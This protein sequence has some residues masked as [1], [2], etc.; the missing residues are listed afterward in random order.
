MIRIGPERILYCDTDSIM[1]LLPKG[2][3]DMT[4]HGL[5]NWV[6][7]YPENRIQRLTALAPKF[8]FLQFDGDEELLKSKG[9]MMSHENR[10]LLNGFTLGKQM[11]E[12]FYPRTNELQVQ[13][14]FQGFIGMK[15]MLIG[16]NSTSPNFAYGTM[17]TKE[18]EDKKLQPVISKRYLVPF[19]QERNVIYD[20]VTA[21][22]YI[23]RIYTLPKGY[24]RSVEQMSIEFY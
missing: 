7:E 21:L 15:N 20:E 23:P 16:I 19:L 10:R 11:L 17:L 4:G 12:L 8:Y 14:P 18:T 22:N 5:G 6:N 1:A 3:P 9:I 2:A 13:L 24:Y